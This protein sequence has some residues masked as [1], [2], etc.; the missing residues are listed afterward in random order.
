MSWPESM[1]AEILKNEPIDAR[2][3]VQSNCY[4]YR[5][6]GTMIAVPLATWMYGNIGPAP[7][8][9]LLSILPLVILPLIW[10]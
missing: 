9:G 4:A 5:F 8:I 1:V 3:V 7:I 2:G 6:F 10:Y